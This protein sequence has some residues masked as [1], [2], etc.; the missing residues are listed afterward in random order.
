MTDSERIERLS[1]LVEEQSAIAQTLIAKTAAMRA[2]I[3]ALMAGK[4]DDPAFIQVLAEQQISLES[5]LLNSETSDAM[6]EVY[7]EDFPHLLSG[8]VMAQVQQ[9]QQSRLLDPPGHFLNP[10][11]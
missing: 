3:R 10:H 6:I 5:L 4:Q 2:V 9:Y 1:K 7:R 8:E 11:P